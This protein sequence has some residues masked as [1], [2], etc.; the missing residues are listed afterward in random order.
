MIMVK[1]ALIVKLTFFVRLIL[2]HKRI[3]FYHTHQPAR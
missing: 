2:K 1:P 3:D